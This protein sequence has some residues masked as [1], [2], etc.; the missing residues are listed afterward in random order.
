MPPPD[1]KWFKGRA[2]Y[3]ED[4]NRE[5]DEMFD[6]LDD[7]RH[8]KWGM[9]EELTEIDWIHESR[10][11]IFA[12]QGDSAKHILADVSPSISLTPYNPG[13]DDKDKAD[14]H[15]K[16]LRW[17]LDS[18]SRRRQATIVQDLVASAVD[19]SEVCAQVVYIPQ[20]IKD[21]EAAG[22][23]AKRYEAMLRR[24]P[25]AVIIHNPGNVYARYSDLGAEEVLLV[26]EDDPHNVIDLWGKKADGL[27]KLMRDAKG[28]PPDTV[29]L[30]DYTSYDYRAVWVDFGGELIEIE[31]GEWPWPF[32]NWVCRYGGTSLEEEGHFQRKPLLANMYHFDL[33]DDLNRVRSLRFSEMIRTA[34]R[35]KDVF[36]SDTRKAPDIDASTGDLYV[37]IDTEENI[38]P[39]PDNVPDTAMSTLYAEL[40][41]D[42]QKSGLSEMLLGAEVP[43][44]AAFASI[45]LVTES[46]LKVLRSS[47]ALAQFSV[48]DVLEVM[49]LYIH[50]A[51]VEVISYGTGKT[52]KGEQYL[53]KGSEI[54]PENL[55]INVKLDAD[56]PTDYQA[57]TVTARAQIDAGINSRENAM[58]D[59]GVKNVS[60][61]KEE[62]AGER[63]EE[64]ML[65]IELENIQFQNSVQIQEQ[66]RQEIMQQIMQDPAFLQQIAQQLGAQQ[67]GGGERR[68]GEPPRGVQNFGG[69]VAQ[70]SLVPSEANAA[71]GG[72]TTEEFA[73][74]E[75]RRAQQEGLR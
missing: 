8:G 26:T 50:Y 54:N 12:Q 49:L 27:K 1:L 59:I 42:V 15:E 13:D 69:E 75:I 40:R 46:A 24:G 18:T 58:E 2:N 51:D 9:P 60:E 70:E 72:P 3:L 57:R 53:I 36:Q 56:L 33:Y 20:Q 47:Q 22:G 6:A 48:A 17:L 71:G 30:Y 23:N 66:M 16:G 68:P 31:R 44:G 64:T 11:P 29:E 4:Q 43:T 52:D 39:Q 67:Q 35:A 74:Q 62:I 61:V 5:R 14:K 45:N 34:S 10:D 41:G 28:G 37:H 55:Y 63:L 73:P 32:M 19:Y 21:I 7:Y 65:A 25:F 38:I